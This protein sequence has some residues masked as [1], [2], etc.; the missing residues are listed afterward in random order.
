LYEELKESTLKQYIDRLPDAAANL[1]QCKSTYHL[2]KFIENGS[3]YGFQT[4]SFAIPDSVNA[5]VHHLADV[6][7]YYALTYQLKDAKIS[8][9]GYADRRRFG[10]HYIDIPKAIDVRLDLNACPEN[11]AKYPSLIRKG[12]SQFSA[13]YKAKNNCHLSAARAKSVLNLLSSKVNSAHF[14]F[15][16]AAG[17]VRGKTKKDR[18]KHRSVEI[19][20]HLNAGK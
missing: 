10:K 20:I 18:P 17:G 9:V 6:L 3:E 4:G 7:N 15:E 13:I 12:S 14:K 11:E 1:S 5:Y 2:L 19:K 16:Y 8:I